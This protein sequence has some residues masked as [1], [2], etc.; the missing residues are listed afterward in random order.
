MASTLN[1][2]VWKITGR[3]AECQVCKDG[4]QRRLDNARRHEA[5]IPH[6]DALS[7][8][9][10]TAQANGAART[11]L[12]SIQ[13]TAPLYSGA[14]EHPLPFLSDLF[15]RQ[16]L[17]SMV[18]RA[19][20]GGFP[21][22]DSNAEPT[23]RS[24]PETLPPSGFN[25][26]LFESYGGME[27]DVPPEVQGAA[28]IAEALLRYQ[29]LDDDNN[30]G[31]EDDDGER[32]DMDE[33][34]PVDPFEELREAQQRA[35]QAANEPT[36]L[37]AQIVTDAAT[38]RYWY[39]WTNRLECT[40]D[41]LMHLPRSVFSHKQLDL[42]LWLLSANSVPDVLSVKSMQ[43]LNERLQK[44]CGIESIRYNGALGHVYYV[45]S[46]ADIIAQEMANPNVLL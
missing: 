27:V 9:K 32:S 5:S 15:S 8:L 13:N 10:T 43:T 39:P 25:W 11:P 6:Q 36:R 29:E 18:H 20:P 38:A 31:D 19:N 21:A 26:D 22:P 3:V 35:Q 7:I 12:Q 2:Q 30:S 46:L 14:G 45:N 41:I 33:P 16:L 42:F 23:T 17:K 1:P 40:L 34:T 37:P 28:R 4:K 24:E 44:L